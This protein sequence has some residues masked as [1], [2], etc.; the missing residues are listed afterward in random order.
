MLRRLK[1]V[2]CDSSF[3]FDFF[4]HF[5][6][7]TGCRS[8]GRKSCAKNVIATTIQQKSAAKGTPPLHLLVM[9][10]LHRRSLYLGRKLIKHTTISTRKTND[11]ANSVLTTWQV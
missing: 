9:V 7:L 4:S 10:V 5:I 6:L 1:D 2:K 8:A 3:K 11:S